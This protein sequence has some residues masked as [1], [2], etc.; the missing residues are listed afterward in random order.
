VEQVEKSIWFD[1]D[2]TV[3]ELYAVENWLEKLRSEN[4]EPYIVAQPKVNMIELS[5]I[6]YAL[7]MQGYTIGV[8]TWLSMQASEEYKQAVRKAKIEWLKNH[9]PFI[10]DKIHI[11]KYGAPKH[12]IPELRYGIL[13][14]DNSEVREKWEKYGGKTID[15]TPAN[16]LDKLKELVE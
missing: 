16:W 1:M 15:A 7:K 5:S 9:I 8:I 14:D 4:P 3:A 13:V 12:T 6:L 10:F 11:V 2:G